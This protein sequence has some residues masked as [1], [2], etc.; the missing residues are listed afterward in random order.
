MDSFIYFLLWVSFQYCFTLWLRCSSFG[1]WELSQV[2]P[3]PTDS[4]PHCIAVVPSTFL[5]FGTSAA[6]HSFFIFATLV[7]EAA[8]YLSSASFRWRMVLET[9]IW[10]WVCSLPQ[11]YHCSQALSVDRTRKYMC[12]SINTCI[13]IRGAPK[14]LEGRPLVVQASLTR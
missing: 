3:Y 5:L 8:I 4:P 2:A 12:V 14:N 11:G 7:L 1:H 10:C 13:H 6:P 9:K